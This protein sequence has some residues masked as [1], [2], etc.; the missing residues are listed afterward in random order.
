MASYDGDVYKLSWFNQQ[1]LFGGPTN[2]YHDGV[3]YAGT[4]DDDSISGSDYG[5]QQRTYVDPSGTTIF[6]M[7][8]WSGNDTLYGVGGNDTITGD[9]GSDQIYGG[10]GQDLLLGG[11]GAYTDTL[12]GDA[13]DD[14]VNG[15]A[16]SDFIDGGTG[17]DT[18]HGGQDDDTL[19]GGDDADW[20]SGDLGND[21][22]TG[23]AGADVFHTYAST[24]IDRVTDFSYTAGDRVQID[25]GTSY[26]VSQVGSDVVIDMGGG[27]QMIL[28]GVSISSLGAGWIFS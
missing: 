27:N 19:N 22:M 21:T 1:Q 12:S 6:A 8:T 17:N 9:S 26:S 4:S 11:T 28:A 13:G 24:G 15:N 2:G 23:G 25:A 7:D 20:L 5:T 3:V 10:D 18:L 16:G 14:N